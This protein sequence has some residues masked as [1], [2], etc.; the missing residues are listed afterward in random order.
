MEYDDVKKGMIVRIAREVPSRHKN[1]ENSWI[2]IMSKR[3]GRVA[4]VVGKERAGIRLEGEGVCDVMWPWH[5]LELVSEEAAQFKGKADA[6]EIVK[7]IYKH[8]G[9]LPLGRNTTHLNKLVK[10]AIKTV[11]N[12]I[13]K[14]ETKQ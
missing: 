11:E 3:L 1:W 12:V 14:K 4:R 13:S 2:T 9:A 7:E 10:K 6:D 5:S 8:M